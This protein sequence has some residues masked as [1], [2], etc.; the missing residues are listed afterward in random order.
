MVVALDP[1]SRPS[2]DDGGQTVPGLCRDGHRERAGVD[3]VPPVLGRAGPR[4]FTQ[5]DCLIVE[6]GELGSL[7]RR[8]GLY[9]SLLTNWRGSCEQRACAG[10]CARRRRVTWPSVSSRCDPQRETAR[11]EP[12]G[13]TE[14]QRASTIIQ[15]LQKKVAEIWRIPL[16]PIDGRRVRLMA[17]E[18]VTTDGRH[19]LCQCVACC[20]ASLYRRRQPAS[21]P[22]TPTPLRER[23]REALGPADDHWQ[24]GATPRWLAQRAVRGSVARRSATPR[25]SKL[26]TSLLHALRVSHSRR[27]G[28]E[29]PGAATPRRGIRRTRNRSSWRRPRTQDLVLTPS[30]KLKGPIPYLSDSACK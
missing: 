8:E 29:D 18:A 26:Q 24:N 12:S 20:A 28:V 3:P 16:K 14:A 17:I 1:A 23:C 21:S 13:C 10:T 7:L 6:A 27:R 9:S 30:T 4:S 2:V 25:C 22:S 19:R 5:A 15:S 11:R